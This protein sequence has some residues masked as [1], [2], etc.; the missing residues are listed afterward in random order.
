MKLQNRVFVVTGGGNGIGREVVLLLLTRGAR[1]AAVDRRA[2]ALDTT[3]ELAGDGALRL[4]SHVADITDP[5]AVDAV[6]AEILAAHGHVDGLLNVAGVIQ[7]FV[8]IADLSLEE[9][10]RVMRVNFWGTVHMV[11]AFLPVLL[12]RPE[13]AIVDV[14]SMGGLVPVPGQ[15]AYGASKAAVKLF[16][17]DLYAELRAT[18]VAVTVVFPGGVG[19]N[20]T[21]NSGVEAPRM[22]AGAKE[23]TVTAPADAARMIVDG[24]VEGRFRVVIGRDARM[25]DLM[26]R[27]APRRAITMIADKMSA[28]L[29]G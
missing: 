17:E 19:T 8:P 9:V 13:A 15:G 24:M 4:T 20:I 14:S 22:A 21:A 26:G 18:H 7:R 6:R 10:D 11:K 29:A 1:V 2:E 12:E 16:T 28:L 5:A 25:L 27:I 3:R 23:P